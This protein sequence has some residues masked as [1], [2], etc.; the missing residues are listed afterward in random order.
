[1]RHQFEDSKRLCLLAFASIEAGHAMICELVTY[2]YQNRPRIRLEE[3]P[4]T[5]SM[6]SAKRDPISAGRTFLFF[7]VPQ[8]ADTTGES[9]FAVIGM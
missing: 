8:N 7:A 2:R 9:Q 5:V 3:N 4:E 1:M 6:A